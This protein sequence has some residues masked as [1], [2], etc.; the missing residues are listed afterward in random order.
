MESMAPPMMSAVVR[1]SASGARHRNRRARF[2]TAPYTTTSTRTHAVNG[3]YTEQIAE[4]IAAF[5]AS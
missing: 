5:L 4:D 2:R 3:E 1:L